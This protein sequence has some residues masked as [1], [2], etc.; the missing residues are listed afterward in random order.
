MTCQNNVTKGK[1]LVFLIRTDDE[2]TFQ[3]LGGVQ[4]RGYTV[5]NPVEETT[6]SS[7]TSEYSESEWTGYSQLTMNISGVTDKRTGTIDPATGFEIV[8]F[9]RIIS[10]GTSGNRCVYA[11]ILSVDPGFKFF[12]EG[13]FSI[14]NLGQSG[15][16]PGLLSGTATLQSKSDIVVQVGN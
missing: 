12:S 9:D 13:Y 3:I 14:T 2:T 7:T 8:G 1:E 16:T 10:L 4:E 5:D 6:S 11:K 15:S